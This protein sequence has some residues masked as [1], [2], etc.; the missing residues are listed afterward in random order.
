MKNCSGNIL[1]LLS[2][3]IPKEV[4]MRDRFEAGFHIYDRW[5]ALWQRGE[6]LL[7]FFEDNELKSV[8]IYGM[9]SLGERLADELGGTSVKV[10]Y[11][12]DRMAEKKKY[13]GLVIYCADEPEYP[14]AD[15]ICVTPV[16]VYAEVE[17]HL[18]ERTQIPVISLEDVVNYCYERVWFGK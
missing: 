11:G 5:L 18:A 14:Y 12:I 9:G 7:P 1:L 2:A 17:S 13:G 4:D 15:A 6:N 10:V 16:Q 3:M 8:A